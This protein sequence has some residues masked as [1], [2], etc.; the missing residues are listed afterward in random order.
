MK[1]ALLASGSKGNCCLIKDENSNILIDCG[2]TKTYLKQCF[3]QLQYDYLKSDAL[4]I[5]HTHSD[6]IAQLKMFDTITTYSRSTLKTNHF[7]QLTTFDEVRVNSLHVKELPLS[8]DSENASGFIV[9]NE[10]KK[11]VYITDTGYLKEDYLAMI[12]NADYYILESNHDVEM[13][14][15]TKRPMYIKQRILGDKGHLCNEDSAAILANVIGDKT[16]EIVLA[17]ISEE[18]NDRQKA[19]EVLIDALEQKQIAYHDIRIV[20]APQFEMVLGGD[21]LDK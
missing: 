17:H 14:M 18:G 4:F 9:Q 15:S 3:E 6:H 21:Q 19:K 5:T 16:K 1:F 7:N 8:H 20:C 10:D 12:Q 13:L 2:A 11:L